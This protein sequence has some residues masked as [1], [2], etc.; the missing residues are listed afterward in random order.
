[1][2]VLTTWSSG[3]LFLIVMP[4]MGCDGSDDISTGNTMT[5]QVNGKLISRNPTS[6]IVRDSLA[7]LDVVRDGEGFAIL[8]RNEM[9][10]VQVSG[11]RNIGFDAEYQEG[12]VGN[13]YRAEN[14]SLSLDDVAN[15]MAEYLDGE[16]E[17]KNYGKWSKITW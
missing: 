1:M 10:Y 14:E 3:V 16:V 17:W 11:D 12:D 9:T 7:G 15:M 5:L 4:F 2:R 8:S 6:K 13:H